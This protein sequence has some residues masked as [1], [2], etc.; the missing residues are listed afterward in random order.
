M[1]ITGSINQTRTSSG[2][3][4]GTEEAHL[5]PCQVFGV[6][7]GTI[8]SLLSTETVHMYEVLAVLR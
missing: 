7:Q 5:T 1:I 4:P 2:E 6:H 3:A 8:V